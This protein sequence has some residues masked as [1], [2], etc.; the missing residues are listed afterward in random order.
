M[1]L[2]EESAAETLDLFM[3]A[4]VGALM[5]ALVN[6]L[7]VYS[8]ESRHDMTGDRCDDFWECLRFAFTLSSN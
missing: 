1:R 5:G 4:F 3:N 8:G 7:V 6:V 2:L